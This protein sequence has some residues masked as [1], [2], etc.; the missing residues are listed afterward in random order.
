MVFDCLEELSEITLSEPTTPKPFLHFICFLIRIPAPQSLNDFEKERWS[1]ANRFRKDLQQ[2]TLIIGIGKNT[3][4]LQFLVLIRREQVTESAREVPVISVAWPC[5]ELE[6]TKVLF[7]LS[8]TLN[9]RKDIIRLESEV[10]QS[11]PLVL[12]QKCLDL[13]F[14]SNDFIL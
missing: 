4:F 3:E 12:F 9:G 14:P 5:H 6:S 1:I 10:L 2:N 11:R 13:G 7:G 8:H